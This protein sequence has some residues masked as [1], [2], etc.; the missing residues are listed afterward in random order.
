V[1]SRSFILGPAKTHQ[2]TVDQNLRSSKLRL[3]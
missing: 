3:D 2:V 1:S